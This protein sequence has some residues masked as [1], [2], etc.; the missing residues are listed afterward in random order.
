M[1]NSL[2][3]IDNRITNRTELLKQLPSD[4]RIIELNA[5]QDGLQQIADAVSGYSNL[6]SIHL[7]SHGS[8]GALYLGNSVLNSQTLPN[9]STALNT[10][11]NSLSSTGDM[12]LYGC[13][14]AEGET[15][16]AFIAQLAQATGADVAASTDITG[17]GGDW[18]LEAQQGTI[19]SQALELKGV[20]ALGERD[21]TILS[22]GSGIVITD[23]G[24]S[25]WGTSLSLQ[26]DGKILLG[27][28]TYDSRLGSSN[29]AL[30]RYNTDGSLDTSFSGDG[31][32]TTDLGGSDGGG[33]LSVQADGKILLG[34]YTYDSRLG[35]SNF[36][37]VRYNTDGSLDTSFSGDG[38]LTTDF[39]SSDYGSSLTV[40]ADGK[41]LL[42]GR[43]NSNFAL[44]RYNTDGSLD[45]SFSGD[46]MLT[47]DLGGS[48]GGS[49][50]SLQ[51]DGKILLGGSTYDSNNESKN[52][53]LVR[54]NTDG[55]L[56]TSFSGDGMLT[57]DLGSWD[58]G[59][60]LSL[61]TDGKIL[62]GS[63]SYDGNGNVNPNF[64]LVRY[65]TDGSLDTSFS[66]DGM[67][68]TDLG[69]DN[70]VGAVGASLSLQ[71]DGKILLGG[72]SYDG[73]A[74]LNFALVRYN[75]DGS[76]DSSFSDDGMLTTDL[77]GRDWGKSLSLQADGKIL[78]GGTSNDNF[79]LVRYNTDGSLDSSFSAAITGSLAVTGTAT[80]GQ[81]LSVTNS[82]IDPNGINSASLRYQWLADGQVIGGATGNTLA[83]TQA[84][85]GKAITLQLDYTDKAGLN[86][87]LLSATTQAVANINDAPTGDVTISG[88]ATQNQ[89]LT[90]I[91]TLADVDG[92]GEISYQ[93]L[94]DGVAIE[95]ETTTSLALTQA[96]VGKAISVQASYTDG[97]GMTESVTSAATRTVVNVND[98]PTGS[99]TISGIAA[100]NETL[101]ASNTLA[102]DADG[103][104]VISYQWLA[105]GHFISGATGE[106]LT[107]TQAQV[108]KTISVQASYTDGQ[109]T[110]ERITST[111]TQA[112]TNVNDAPTGSVAISGTATQ[113]RTLTA[114]NT[115]ADADGM[116]ALAY[117]WLA[118][119]VVINGATARTLQLTQN[120]VNQAISVQIRYTD[121]QG[122][123]ET[124]SSSATTGVQ[125][126]NDAPT[127]QLNISG[128]I[129]ED[130]LIGHELSAISTLADTDG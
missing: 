32:L 128:L 102:D 99:V 45:T 54:Y 91:S 3:F 16:A 27:G 57:T 24:G 7:I 51:A 41:I 33:S 110:L 34:G 119:G 107:L 82:V 130:A 120:Q 42:G 14:V 48:D 49:S 55:S 9:Y 19:E 101:T 53:A 118:D 26:A 105:N 71:T 129:R 73:N 62:L 20:E 18:D 95:G 60:S 77:G 47:T 121:S 109:N 17:Q 36:A 35:S 65:N 114:T 23:L 84:E 11:G 37:L 92:L 96:L 22:Q 86:K 52:F 87:S 103:M 89:T 56:D 80:Q 93:W 28:Y 88:T 104:G 12:L 115:L 68:T 100:Q 1:P 59:A 46:G 113:G 66:G 2:I 98:T 81:V 29:F 85:V 44:V 74:N 112:I 123:V 111:A 78:L 108:G 75:T 64:A 40:Q 5:T 83:L 10:I 97:F 122:T 15:G 117:Q 30:V 4:S 106:T 31:M 127:G 124:I 25:D 125:N 72:Y 63:H 90:A 61:Q 21:F 50:L 126:I 67:L 94:A 70:D 38:M 76:L 116:G 79:A 39:G 43:G 58:E 8:A 13:N 69:G 6:D